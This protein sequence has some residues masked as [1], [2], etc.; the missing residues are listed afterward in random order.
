[1]VFDFFPWKIEADI[2]GT[3][4]LYQDNDYSL[5]K[6]WNKMFI[7]SLN[8]SQYDFFDRLG[9]DLMKIDIEKHDLID[10]EVSYFLSINFLFYGKFLAMP[11]EQIELYRDEEIYGTGMEFKSVETVM[12]DKLA[13]YDGL[14]LEGTGIRF[15]HPVSHFEGSM[16]EKW[17]CGLINGALIV[18]G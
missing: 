11:K 5:N 1:M 16:F 7:N 4:R 10:V 12:C 3:K 6:E 9:I 8:E 2:E 13:L 17:D 14:K 15:K 18:R